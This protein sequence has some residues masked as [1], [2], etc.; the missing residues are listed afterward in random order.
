MATNYFRE[1]VDISKIFF[2]QMVIWVVAMLYTIEDLFLLF[3]CWRSQQRVI[4]VEEN[5]GLKMKCR[6][7][8]NVS[9][10]GLS[11]C[12]VFYVESNLRPLVG[13]IL[14]IETHFI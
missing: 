7:A 6:K 11:F 14:N 10:I 9:I 2:C 8:Q 13:S 1:N 4:N 3:G 12:Y 5:S